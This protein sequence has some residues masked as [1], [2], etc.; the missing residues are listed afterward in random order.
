MEQTCRQLSESQI[1]HRPC[2]HKWFLRVIENVGQGVH[3][4]VKVGDINPHGLLPHGRLVCVSGGLKRDM[5]STIN[6]NVITS[7]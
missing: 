4:H 3:A 2:S 5:K 7:I 6:E 1:L